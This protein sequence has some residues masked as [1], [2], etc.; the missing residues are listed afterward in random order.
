MAKQTKSTKLATACVQGSPSPN[1]YIVTSTP[2]S[3]DC[4]YAPVI[5]SIKPVIVQT[6]M[7]STKV[8]VIDTSPCLTGSFVFAAAAAIGAVPSPAS[9][10]KIPLATPF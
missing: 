5:T 1:P 7:V 8:P 10:E 3:A 2:S 4:L 6:I 9:F